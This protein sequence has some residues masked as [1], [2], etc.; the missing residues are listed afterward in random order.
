[1]SRVRTRGARRVTTATVV[2]GHPVDMTKTLM[3][4][5][6]STEDFPRES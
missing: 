3:G 6:L 5:E 4:F 1:M 2:F